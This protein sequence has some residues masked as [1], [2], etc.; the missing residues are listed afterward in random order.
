MQDYPLNHAINAP[1]Y[2]AKF[3]ADAVN[4]VLEQLNADTLRIWYVSQQEETDSQLHFYDGKY[5]I[6]DISDDEIASWK[7]PSEFK[8]ALPTVNN[9]LPENF[10]IKTQAFKEQKHPELAYDKN[11]V[12]V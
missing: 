5:R 3:D 2:Y 8:L 11:G 10:A 6:S 7:K 4:N 1:Y 12:K 9:L